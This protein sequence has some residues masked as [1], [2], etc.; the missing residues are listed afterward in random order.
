MAVRGW[1]GM[2]RPL[3]SDA[4]W[5]LAAPLLPERPPRPKGGR[6]PLDRPQGPGRHRPSCS[7]PAS[8]GRACPAMGCGSG[9]T[10]WRRLRDWQAAGVFERLHRACSTG[11]A[12]RTRSTSAAARSTAPPSRRKGGR[13]HRPEPDRPRQARLQAPR[14]RRRERRPARAPA[15]R[16]ERPRQPPLRAAARRRA[17]DPAVRRAAAKRPAKLHADKGTTTTA[18]AAPAARRA[19]SPRIARRGVESSG[20]AWAGTGG[21]SSARWRG[22]RASAGSPSATS[23]GSTSCS[24]FHLLA[25]ALVCLRFVARWSC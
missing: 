20:A 21:W 11:S 16:R 23:A 24:A 10:C 12:G 1:L 8:R 25:A 17:A 6:P 14:P 22:S 19:S 3:V 9:M 13:A 18:A 2:A 15:Q 5:A 7:A 4:L